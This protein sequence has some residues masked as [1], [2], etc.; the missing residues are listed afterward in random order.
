MLYK[1]NLDDIIKSI[2]GI[3]IMSD[4]YNATLIIT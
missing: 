4:S 3:I 1:R 2:I